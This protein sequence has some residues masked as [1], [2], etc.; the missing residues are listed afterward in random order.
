MAWEQNAP[1]KLVGYTAGA[2]LNASQYRFVTLA[3]SG[4]VVEA[5]DNT[6]DRPVGVLV[7][8]PNTGQEA[9]VVVLGVTK[10]VAGETLAVG[11]SI[12][13]GTA[14]KAA[15]AGTTAGDHNVG[16]VL[17]AAGADGVYATVAVNCVNV[18]R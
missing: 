13:V 5:V 1:I 14:G 11:D 15:K 9:E 8:D 4:Q 2:D 16:V 17:S 3:S 18:T 12:K 7:N 6:A 10:I